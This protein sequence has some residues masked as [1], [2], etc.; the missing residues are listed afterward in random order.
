MDAKKI[1]VTTDF[2]KFTENALPYIKTLTK[3]DN[4]EFH[5]LY[6]MQDI[7]HIEP[8]YGDFA[9]DHADKLVQL[10]TK[11]SERRLDQI[12]DKYLEGCSLFT[13]HTALG[14]PSEEI[15][16][17]IE[18]ENIDMVVMTTHPDKKGPIHDSVTKKVLNMS[19]VPVT[20]IEIGSKQM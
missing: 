17:F 10:T 1:L 18:N 4:A 9:W 8:W 6:V 16:K 12:C 14:E 15:L 11:T 19:P 13:K 5:I 3:E 2:N 7:A 20:T